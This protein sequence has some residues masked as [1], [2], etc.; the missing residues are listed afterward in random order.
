MAKQMTVIGET[1]ERATDYEAVKRHSTA[2][3]HLARI[4]YPLPLSTSFVYG[5]D[6]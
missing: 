5:L 1:F 4:C 6:V 3:V 2:R